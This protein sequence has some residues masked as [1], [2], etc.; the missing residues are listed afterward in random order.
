MFWLRSIYTYSHVAQPGV[1]PI[2]LVGTHKDQLQGV[3]LS[4]FAL[5]KLSSKCAFLMEI[6]TNVCRSKI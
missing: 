1:P 6:R 4:I 3:L 2:I 5:M